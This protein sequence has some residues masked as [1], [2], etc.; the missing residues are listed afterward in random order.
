MVKNRYVKIKN[1][2]QE[3]IRKNT[4][5]DA[6]PEHIAKRQLGTLD[7]TTTGIYETDNQFELKNI[8]LKTD[9]PLERAK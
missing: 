7:T 1:G 8:L 3:I 9:T 5:L 2:K 4:I 6:Y